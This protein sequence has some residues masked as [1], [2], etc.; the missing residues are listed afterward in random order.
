LQ[1]LSKSGFHA[2][3]SRAKMDWRLLHRFRHKKTLFP[4]KKKHKLKS[5]IAA[6]TKPRV[7]NEQNL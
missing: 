4:K 7:K 5:S 1:P 6:C 3:R 2:V